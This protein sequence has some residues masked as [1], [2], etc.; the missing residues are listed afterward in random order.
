MTINERIIRAV[1]TVV[2]V[3][4][5]NI[6]RGEQ[7]TY[8]TFNYTEIPVGHGDNSP[9][10]VRYLIQVHFHCPATQNSVATRKALRK[11]LLDADFTAP[12]ISDLTDDLDQHYVLECEG[13]EGG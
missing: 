1:T 13:V 7:E 6:Y 10:A 9:H 5:P 4:T 11:A 12:V 2:P 8:C 3:C